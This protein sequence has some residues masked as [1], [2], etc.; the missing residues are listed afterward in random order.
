VVTAEVTPS[1]ISKVNTALQ[2]GLMM[3]TLMFSY[4]NALDHVILDIMQYTVA[5]TTSI[6]FLDYLAFN[7]SHKPLN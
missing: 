6:S 4:F 3:T 1:L 2:L 7:K 5:G